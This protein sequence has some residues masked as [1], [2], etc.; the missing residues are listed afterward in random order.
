VT[1]GKPK[2]KKGK[3]IIVMATVP[4]AGTLSAG[5]ASDPALATAAKGKP[6]RPVTETLA[7]TTRQEVR[8]VLMRAARFS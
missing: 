7:V 1:L 3:K 6:L 4:G 8:L 2:P 5:V